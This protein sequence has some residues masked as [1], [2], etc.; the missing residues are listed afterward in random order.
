MVNLRGV[1]RLVLDEADR[2]VDMGFLPQVERILP[3]LARERQTLFFSATVE[4]AAGVAA[5]RFTRHPAR[6]DATSHVTVERGE[7][8]HSFISVTEHEKYAQPDR[9][10]GR[11]RR[12]HA[13]LLRDQVRLRL[14]GAPARGHRA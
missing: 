7:V 5:R 1:T 8:D 3:M 4:G 6:I 11:G 10:P 13:R 2:M 14:A 9:A 12:A